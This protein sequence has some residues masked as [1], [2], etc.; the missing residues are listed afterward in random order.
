MTR[1]AILAQTI[2]SGDAVGNDVCGMSQALEA[3]GHDVRIYAE[4]WNVI[5]QK[6]WPASEIA[7]FLKAPSD[8]AI[9][10]HSIGWN[11]GVELLQALEK[12]R[13]VVKYHNVTPPEFFFGVSSDFE[14]RCRLGR[15]QLADL[16][17]AGC[18]LYLADSAFNLQ[19]LIAHGIDRGFIVPPFNHVD[20]LCSSEPDLKVLDACS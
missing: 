2:A 11:Q 4:H 14:N 3:R 17:R 15:E 5:E 10:H 16:A 7:D 6:V 20:R 13:T 8:V 9:Y 1:I 12:N 19:E 18:D